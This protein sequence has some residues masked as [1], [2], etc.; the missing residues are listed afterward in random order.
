MKAGLVTLDLTN[1]GPDRAPRRVVVARDAARA[2]LV[3]TSQESHATCVTRGL[4]DLQVNGAFGH[5]FTQNPDRI[6]DVGRRL[7]EHGVTAF[8]PTIIT[9][10]V[11]RYEAAIAVV[12]AGPPAGYRGAR[13]LGLH[14]EGPYLAPSRCGAH[15]PN[16][17]R[18][19]PG[20]T[21]PDWLLAPELRMV[22]LA[23]ERPG[24]LG[25]TRALVRRGVL[26]S[27]GH[28]AATI[29]EVQR[30]ADCG[31]RAGTHLFNAMTGLHHR[32]PGVAAALLTDQRLTA[33]M[34]V[35][36]V[37]LHPAMVRLAWAA[38]GEG[39]LYLVSDAMAAAGM[40]PGRH[41]LAGQTVLVEN[42]SVR[43]ANGTIA[44][45]CVLLDA[46]VRHTMHQL[47]TGLAGVIPAATSTPMRLL[48][49]SQAES[50]VR[51]AVDWVVFDETT[52]PIM[53]VMDGVVVHDALESEN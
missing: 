33:G 18:E 31:L 29:D 5:D 12:A 45:S 15:D 35:D 42:G 28:S 39:G 3:P 9:A 6:W 23:P 14:F 46:V 4:V 53:T 20:D 51:P 41:E 22:T 21:L 10:P 8:L 26:V 47:S 44:G 19:A 30:A 38:R 34:I 16:W 37:H 25:L 11:T 7:V 13:V 2:T 40:P 50:E 17:L 49:Q 36:G 27:V 32:E 48:G 43:L 1:P 52:R 24:A